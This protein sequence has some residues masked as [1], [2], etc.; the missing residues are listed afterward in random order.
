ML[1]LHVVPELALGEDCILGED[2]HSVEGGISVLLGGE[3]SSYD[4]V[5]SDLHKLDIESKDYL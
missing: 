4:E 1:S 5:L 2:S 3:G